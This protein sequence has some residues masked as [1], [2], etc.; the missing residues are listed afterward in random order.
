MM[1][2]VLEYIWGIVA[3][4][5]LVIAV[6]STFT[7]GA[8]ESLILYLCLVIAAAMFFLR[9]NLNRNKNTGA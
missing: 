8:G 6:H 5:V 4:A 1:A 7:R 3:I 2:K 9:R